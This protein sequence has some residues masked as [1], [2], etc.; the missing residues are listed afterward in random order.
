MMHCCAVGLCGNLNG[1]EVADIPSPQ[2]CIM[3]PKLAAMSYMLN[4]NGNAYPSAGVPQSDH[5][6]FLAQI[7]QC[8]RERVVPTPIVPVFERVRTLVMPLV[9]AHKVE[10][11][12]NRI[13]ISKEKIKVSGGGAG[14]SSQGSMAQKLVKFA[15]VA[16]PSV[17][18]QTLEKRAMAGESLGAEVTG[19]STAYTKMVT[20]PMNFDS[21][22]ATGGMGMGGNGEFGSGGA[23]GT[24]EMG[25]SGSSGMGGNQGGSGIEGS[26]GNSGIGGGYGSSLGNGGSSGSASSMGE[27]IVSMVRQC[28]TYADLKEQ[29]KDAGD[30]LVVIYFYATWC[31]PCH[32]IAPQVEA[33]VTDLPEV[34]FL[35][36]DI[37]ECEEAAQKYNISAMPTFILVKN[38]E[39]VDE[40]VGADAQK[41]KKMILR[42]K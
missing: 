5:A 7:H 19:L 15:C 33:M 16:A 28:T 36:V 9:S 18:A 32:A 23:I 12:M 24:R 42:H 1:E 30:K 40:T 21:F 11:Q 8:A 20:E 41:L 37:D 6:E 39:K 10:K 3:K 14:V 35:K 4:K 31:G 34:L 2:Q 17:Q 26:Y 27:R 22:G 38:Q 29:L 25:Y 13:C